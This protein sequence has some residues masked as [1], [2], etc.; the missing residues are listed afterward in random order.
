MN[1]IRIGMAGVLATLALNVW[2]AGSPPPGAGKSMIDATGTWTAK[3]EGA[4]PPMTMVFVLK[5]DKKKLTGTMSTNGG[6][7]VEI[8][9]GKALRTTVYFSVET[10]MPAMPAMPGRAGMPPP[11][12]QQ[13][14]A[15]MKMVTKYEGAID[16]DTMTLERQG[17]MGGGGGMGGP[18]GGGGM[19]GGMGGPGMG[20]MMGGMGKITATRSK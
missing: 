5:Q 17:G 7:P 8:K 20:G 13:P 15:P 18:P 14:G 19:G 3:V 9:D 12:N 11:P 2:A 10:T 1:I 4:G 16:G 6:P